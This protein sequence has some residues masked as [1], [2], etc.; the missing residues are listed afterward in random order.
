MAS[1]SESKG[2]AFSTA[3]NISLGTAVCFTSAPWGA[4]LPLRMA[5]A[6]SALMGWS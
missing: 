6:P 1:S 4:R 5:M 2:R 3:R